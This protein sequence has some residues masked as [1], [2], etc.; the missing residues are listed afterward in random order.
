MT[1]TTPGTASGRARSNRAMT[2]MASL[3]LLA[4][5]GGSVAVR[6]DSP[7]SADANDWPTFNHDV[8]GTRYNA[9]EH[10][11]KKSNVGG[12]QVL[13]QF[14][15]PAPVSGTPIVVN[16]TI[17]AGDMSGAFYAL[18]RDGALL[19][20]TQLAGSITASALMAG[21]VVVIGD[22]AGNVYGL[23]RDDGAIEWQMRPDPHPLAS[24]WGSPTKIG[25]YVALGVASNE[26]GAAADPTYPCCSTRGS[27]VMLDPETGTIVWRTFTIT[28]AELA[29]GA[30]G[31]SIWSTPT[32]DSALKLI[33]VTTG[34]NF[35]QPTT[36][37]S[38]AIMAFD[39]D[40]GAIVWTNQRFPDDEWNFRFP[41]SPDHPDADFGDSAQVYTLSGGLRVVGAG[42]KSGFYHVLDA[43]TGDFINMDQFEAGG[44]LG[45]LFADTAVAEGV[46]FAN[47]INWPVPSAAPPVAGDL[48]A[49]SGDA[50]QELWRFTTPFSPDIAGVAV[51]NSVVYF[52]SSYSQL[53][54]ALDAADGTMLTSVPIG[55]SNSGP[56]I[57][58][59]RVYVGTGNAIAAAF[60]L[61][62]GPGSITA[63][64]L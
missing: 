11:L 59:G 24:I 56:S 38:D 39:A 47:G 35:S 37:T 21:K 1:Q 57:S 33:Y 46:V 32:Y 13:W 55:I 51:A 40:T 19:W 5:I 7:K 31:S 15:T 45:G 49:I 62:V 52:T 26:E 53:L 50:S 27:L 60:G 41:Y 48:I 36:D 6:A 43:A 10:T 22:I 2:L 64:G 58:R 28:D 44:L 9:A 54:F 34:N 63:L 18:D 61:G 3:L 30:S 4:T 14:P 17:Y 29:A 42:Q 8:E 25:K 20:S 16:D 12:L 23:D